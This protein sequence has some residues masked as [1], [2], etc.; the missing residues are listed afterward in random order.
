MYVKGGSCLVCEA[1]IGYCFMYGIHAAA[2]VV[3]VV[4]TSQHRKGQRV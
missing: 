1:V 2:V 4:V 3:V